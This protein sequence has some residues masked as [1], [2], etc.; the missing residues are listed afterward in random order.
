MCRLYVT[1]DLTK[2][3]EFA[4]PKKFKDFKHLKNFRCFQFSV[5]IYS[6]LCQSEKTKTMEN[7][8][9]IG[10]QMTGVLFPSTKIDLAALAL[11][12]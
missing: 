2:K 11:E 5:L 1:K 7:L 9:L 6:N 8:N 3:I 4:P 12:S 10:K